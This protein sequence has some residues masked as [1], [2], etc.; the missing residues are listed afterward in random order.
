MAPAFPFFTDEDPNARIKGSRDPLGITTIWSA[1]GRHVVA[2][3][4]ASSTS[5]RSFTIVLLARWL[6]ERLIERGEVPREEALN[7]FLRME[8]VGAYVRYAGHGVEGEIRGIERVK[9]NL[10]EYGGQPFIGTEARATILAD[11]KVYGLWGL[12]SVPARRSGWV[13][14]GPIGLTPIA[15]DFVEA[16][17]RPVLGRTVVAL[18]NLVAKNGGRLRTKGKGDAVFAALCDVLRPEFSEEEQTFYG[19]HLRDCDAAVRVESEGRQRQLRRLLEKRREL[20]ESFGRKEALELAEAAETTDPNLARHLRRIVTLEALIAPAAAAFDLVLVRTGVD[21][22]LVGR[23]LSSLWG[24][25]VPNLDPSAFGELLEEIHQTTS[26]ELAQCMDQAHGAF[27]SGDYPAAIGAL[28]EW[29]R[30][31]T[32]GRGSAPWVRLDQDDRLDVRY[33]GAEQSLPTEEDLGELWS[34]SYFVDSL[35]SIT[36]Q[37]SNLPAKENA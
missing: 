9:G 17:Y 8:Q 28:I 33:R 4:T 25:R 26:A 24:T 10:A 12:Y 21:V 34:N 16:F 6:A 29:N 18:E 2:N 23:E 19:K 22:E 27:A 3:L 35:K 15:R 11:Q 14:E 30:L 20:H 37:L 32:D 5:A 1:F 7:V 36:R 13:A 31:V